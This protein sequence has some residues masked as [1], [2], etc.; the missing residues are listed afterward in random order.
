MP[1]RKDWQ[2]VVIGDKNTYC[3]L[4]HN[5]DMKKTYDIILTIKE[6]IKINDKVQFVDKCSFIVKRKME[7]NKDEK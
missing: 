6:C 7:G 1:A 2:L 3:V 4:L 5:M